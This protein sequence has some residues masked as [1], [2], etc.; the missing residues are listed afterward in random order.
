MRGS[1]SPAERGG[2]MVLLEWQGVVGTA[3]IEI[4]P[5]GGS[6]A[7]LRPHSW[8]SCDAGGRSPTGRGMMEIIGRKMI[9]TFSKH[10][11]EQRQIWVNYTIDPTTPPHHHTTKPAHHTHRNHCKQ[12]NHSPCAV[13]ARRNVVR[14]KIKSDVTR[15]TKRNL[16]RSFKLAVSEMIEV[17]EDFPAR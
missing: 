15:M 7:I 9:E 11:P 14:S 12:A 13:S 1:S 8:E 17:K 10:Q 5:T 6:R 2:R 4:N 3:S 16:R